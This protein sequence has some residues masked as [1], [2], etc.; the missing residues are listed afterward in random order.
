[1]LIVEAEE[2]LVW[3]LGEEEKLVWVVEEL[4]E[5]IVIDSLRKSKIFVKISHTVA[6]YQSVSLGICPGG[7]LKEIK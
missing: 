7:Q 1:M 4:V 2:V 5:E 6:N 3:V